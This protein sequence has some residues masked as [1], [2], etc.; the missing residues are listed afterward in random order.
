MARRGRSTCR[1]RSCIRSCFESTARKA[2]PRAS[3]K[4]KSTAPSVPNRGRR[5]R[6]PSPCESTA[7]PAGNNVG[8]VQKHR[9]DMAL[10]EILGNVAGDGLLAPVQHVEILVPQFGRYLIADVQQLPDVRAEAGVRPIVTQGA[11]ILWCCPSP[12]G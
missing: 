10:E 4:S 1:P 2:G 8:S 11:R 7:V 3:R 6:W 9:A 5:L 12:H